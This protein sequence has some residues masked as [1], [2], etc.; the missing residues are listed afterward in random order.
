MRGNSS[1]LRRAL[2]ADR[3]SS[4]SRAH[5]TRIARTQASTLSRPLPRRM[6]WRW[7]LL[8]RPG[9]ASTVSYRS[10][11]GVTRKHT[12][13]APRT[14]EDS[15]LETTS[16][17]MEGARWCDEGGGAIVQSPTLVT[18]PRSYPCV[19]ACARSVIPPHPRGAIRHDPSEDHASS[20]SLACSRSPECRPPVGVGTDRRHIADRAGR[21]RGRRRTQSGPGARRSEPR[22]PRRCTTLEPRA[23][24]LKPAQTAVS[25]SL[26]PTP[27]PPDLDNR[28][29]PIVD[30]H[31]YLR[32][33]FALY[34]NFSLGWENVGTMATGTTIAPSGSDDG[35]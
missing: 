29:T 30:I 6:R 2:P 22:R 21:Y 35:A 7:L 12:P 32:T 28:T 16:I 18:H 31:G 8:P 27:P 25:R 17:A 14:G 5:H 26:V 15:E 9:G 4:N 34:Q 24:R 23:E 1:R 19:D 33:R 20:R 13:Q 3:F 10:I 11:P